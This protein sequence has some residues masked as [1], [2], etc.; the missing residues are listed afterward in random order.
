MHTQPPDDL[1]FPVLCHYR[2]IAVAQKGMHFVIETVLREMGIASPLEEAN[3]SSGGKY[4][5]YCFSTLVDSRET[6]A[7]IDRE[8][9]LI[10]GVKMVL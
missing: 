9:R 10:Q 5:S 2:V 3:T 8:L 6:I 7:K 1:V 4:V